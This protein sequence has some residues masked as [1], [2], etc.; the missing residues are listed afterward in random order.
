MATDTYVDEGGYVHSIEL[1]DSGN[2][3]ND[4]GPMHRVVWTAEALQAHAI[5]NSRRWFPVL[6][7]Q[8]FVTQAMYHGLGLAGEAGEVADNIKKLVRFWM[9]GDAELDS[10]EAKELKANIAEEIGDVYAYLANI[11]GLLGISIREEYITKSA[12]NETRQWKGGNGQADS[13]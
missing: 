1:D 2:V 11:A 10:P 13:K 6:A 3:I 9:H 7:Q 4:S 5:A 8:P 12:Y